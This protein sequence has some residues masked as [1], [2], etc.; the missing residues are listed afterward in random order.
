MGAISAKV[1]VDMAVSA[2]FVYFPIYFLVKGLF[3]AQSPLASLRE[4]FSVK[5]RS[6]LLRYWRV[7]LPVETIM[8]ACWR[9]KPRPHC[10]VAVSARL[11]LR[12]WLCC[13]ADV[14][15]GPLP[16]AGGPACR[17]ISASPSSAPSP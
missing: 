12:C 11:W 4:Y 14:A 7:W 6:L 3:A 17:P 9:S 2:P 16:T 15:V 8:S 13:R 1:G 10:G 5:G